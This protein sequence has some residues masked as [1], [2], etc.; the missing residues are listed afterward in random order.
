MR[1]ALVLVPV[2][3]ALSLASNINTTCRPS[4]FVSVIG[5]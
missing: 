2:A 1:I 5:H 3:A 4:G